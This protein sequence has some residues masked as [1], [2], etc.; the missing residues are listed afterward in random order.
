M[1]LPPQMLHVSHHELHR[2]AHSG[3]LEETREQQSPPTRLPLL[4]LLSF[5]L[6]YFVSVKLRLAAAMQDF[7]FEM[8]D[9]YFLSFFT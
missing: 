5:S 2:P 1:V 3:L 8:M 6:I 7:H 4:G 9:S